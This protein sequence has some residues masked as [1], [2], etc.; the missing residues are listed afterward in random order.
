MVQQASKGF[1]YSLALLEW[2]V[3][4]TLTFK[5]PVPIE[6]RGWR[7]AW[8]HFHRCAEFLGRPYSS[9]LIALRSE[10]GEIG[11]RWHF[12]YL[13]GATGCSN[14]YSLAF[15]LASLWQETARAHAEIRPYNRTLAGADYVEGCL[16]GQLTKGNLYE[17]GKFNRADRLELS[18]SVFQR[19]GWN[20]RRGVEFGDHQNAEKNTGLRTTASVL[21][22][23]RPALAA[24]Q[25]LTST[26]PGSSQASTM[27]SVEQSDVTYSARGCKRE[28]SGGQV[29]GV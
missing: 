11:N 28:N 2:D 5:N 7:L 13:L 3:F 24:G 14:P 18:V 1:A 10:R 27:G 8:G 15:W 9:L 17:V 25:M 21:N 29:M 6:R 23:Q 4:G 26:L 22:P 16:S 20:L 19:I 12:H